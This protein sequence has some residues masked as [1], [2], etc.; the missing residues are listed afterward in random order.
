M[1]FKVWNEY[2]NSKGKVEDGK[3]DLSGDR[4]D[5]MTAPNSPPG[6]GHKPYC[7]SD[8]KTPKNKKEKGFGDQGDKDLVFNFDPLGDGKAPAKIPTAENYNFLMA[9]RE[10]LKSDPSLMENLVIDLKRN[11]LLGPLVGELMEHQETYKHIAGLMGHKTYGEGVCDK[12]TMAMVKEEVA[13][14][15]SKADPDEDLD[16]PLMGD[17]ESEVGEDEEGVDDDTDMFAADN[18][19]EEFGIDDKEG[20]PGIE[21][22]PMVDPQMMQNKAIF[23][24][25][26][27]F[28][29]YV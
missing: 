25:H 17:E 5:P 18:P 11:G 23:N 21:D 26:K 27:S 29:K 6:K 1:S 8:G 20:G 7:V 24:M 28:M 14:P 22:E 2:L 13:P 9:V 4:V 12:L 3:V 15:F 10:K 19:E 16:A